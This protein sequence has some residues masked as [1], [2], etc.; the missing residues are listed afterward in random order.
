MVQPN[1]EI[2][3]DIDDSV[4][5][6]QE[7][8]K[9]S[10]EHIVDIPEPVVQKAKAPLPKPSPPYPQRLAKKN[11]E[12][13]E[14]MPDYAKFMKDLMTKKRPMNFETIKVTHQVSAIVHSMDHK[15]EDP[16]AFTIPCTIGSAEFAKALC[17]LGASFNLIPYSVF[18]TLGIGKP[19][20]TSMRLQMDDRTM[21][22]PL[23]VIEDILVRVDKFILPANFDI[24]H[25]KVDYE[26]LIILGRPFL[27]MG[28][29]LFDVKARELTFR[30]GYEKVVFHVCKSMLQPSSNQVDSTLVVLQKRKKVIGWTLTDIRGIS[31]AFCMHKI[32][33]EDGAKPSIEHQRRLDEAF[34]TLLSKYGVTHKVKT[35]YHPQTSGQVEVSNREIKSTLSKM[36]NVNQT[37]WSKKLDDALWAYWMAYKTQIGMSPYRLVLGK[38]CHLPVELEHKAMWALKKLNLDWDVAANLRVA[39]LNELDEFQY[40]AYATQSTSHAPQAP[41]TIDETLKKILEN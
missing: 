15:L 32:K 30:V 35:P 37:D 4:E 7:K 10:R 17:D 9:P 23:G 2:R 36:V 26:V 29:A 18:K 28:K 21:K 25:C 24:L 41:S 12:A 13:L 8:V 40:H 20:P 5:E 6:T 16:G 11:V 27:A 38:A 14:Q 39:H 1:E 31:L 22:R 3:I 34:D 33:L 19:R